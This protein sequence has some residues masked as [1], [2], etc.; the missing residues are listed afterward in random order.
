MLHVMGTRCVAWDLHTIAPGPLGHACWR[1]FAAQWGDCKKSQIVSL[2]EIIIIIIMD[3]Q[4]M[5]NTWHCLDLP[6]GVRIAWSSLT[7]LTVLLDAA[8]GFN[9]SS[10]C[11]HSAEGIF[12]LGVNMASDSSQKLFRLRVKTKVQSVQGCIPSHRL[13]RYWHPCPRQANTANKNTPSIHHP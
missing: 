3:W 13:N 5:G 11:S 10:A 6:M 4:K 9:P 2:N 1:R 7:G 8:R 12:P